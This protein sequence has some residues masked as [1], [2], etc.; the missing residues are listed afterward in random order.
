[1]LSYLALYL[2]LGTYLEP[3]FCAPIHFKA[4]FPNLPN[5]FLTFRLSILLVQQNVLLFAASDCIILARVTGEYICVF[6]RQRCVLRFHFG[7]LIRETPDY[8]AILRS[9]QYYILTC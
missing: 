5:S 9:T 1:M 8:Y 3:V 4:W 6:L 2:Q 7:I